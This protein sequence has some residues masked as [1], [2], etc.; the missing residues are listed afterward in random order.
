M[1]PLVAEEVIAVPLP[2]TVLVQRLAVI[3]GDDDDR[4]LGEPVRLERV[5]H[6][7]SRLVDRQHGAVVQRRG[8]ARSSLS[9]AGASCPSPTGLSYLKRPR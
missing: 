6:A 5:E 4:L 9:S 7:L 1:R 2:V 8:P 3:G